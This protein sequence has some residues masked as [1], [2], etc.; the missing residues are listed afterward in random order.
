MWVDVSFC[1]LSTRIT[2]RRSRATDACVVRIVWRN[3]ECRRGEESGECCLGCF[4]CL[5]SGQMG[6]GK[7]ENISI[8]LVYLCLVTI[9][10]CCWFWS[11]MEGM[12]CEGGSLRVSSILWSTSMAQ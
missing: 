6:G 1:W 9:F 7:G 8:Y 3:G 12:L 11:Y 4:V 5:E 2:L 10:C